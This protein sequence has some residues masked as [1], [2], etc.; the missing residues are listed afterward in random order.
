MT[1]VDQMIAKIYDLPTL[2]DVITRLS[3]II[4]SDVWSAADFEEVVE[5]DPSLTANLLRLANSPYF[6]F[7]RKITTVRQAVTLM[8]VKRVFELA[9]GGAFSRVIPDQIPGYD[10][11]AKD[12]WQHSIAVAILSE[13]LVG[14]LKI[15]MP[16]LMFTAGLLHDVGKIVLGTFLEESAVDL[17]TKLNEKS[18]AFIE[19]EREL[20]GADHCEVG[21]AV[22]KKWNLPYEVEVATMWH[23]KPSESPEKSR[24]LIDLVHAADN[25]AHSMALGNDRGGLARKVDPGTINRLKLTDEILQKVAADGYEQIISMSEMMSRK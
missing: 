3:T 13:R 21:S 8:G 23:H 6:G 22:A 17:E 1:T 7:P 11:P 5:P 10:L 9:A 25:L 20:L 15:S 14:E 16:P 2:P 12:F 19:I 4:S 18:L 24:T